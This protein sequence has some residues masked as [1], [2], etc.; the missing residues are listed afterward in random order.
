MG[1]SVLGRGAALLVPAV[2]CLLSSAPKRAE[3][4]PLAL[5]QVVRYSLQN[6]GDL[7]SFREEKGIRD[8]GKTRAGVLPNPTLELEGESGACVS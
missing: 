4:E 1:I 3:A 5:Q 7:K 8:A 6:N 2:V